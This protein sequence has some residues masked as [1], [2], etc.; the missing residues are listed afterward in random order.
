[1]FDNLLYQNVSDLL[2]SDIYNDRFPGSILLSGPDSSG[3]LT[4]ALEIARILSCKEKGEWACKCSS[5][6]KHKALTNTNLLLAGPRD[7]SLEIAASQKAFL[8]SAQSKDSHLVATR[9]LFIRSVRK[10]IL[11]F[12]PILY[13]GDD[14]LSKISSYTSTINEY[15][16]ELD[17]PRDLPNYEELESL[18]GNICKQCEKLETEFMYDSIP[19]NQIRNMSAWVHVPLPDA[20]K[21]V[22]I[23]K[24]DR[25]LEGVRNAM[26]KI[27]EEPPANTIFILTTSR[28]G[29][30]MPTILSRVR[31]Y[32]FLERGEQEQKE[33][34]SRVYH[35][36][37]N[38]DIDSYLQT[39][40]PIP[41]QKVQESA[42]IF[43]KTI[44]NSGI[45]NVQQIVKDCDK[46][47]PR[48]LMRIFLESIINQLDNY[49]FTPAG[50]KASVECLESIKNC[51]NNITIY[52]QSP[53]A[54]LEEL[55]KN[56]ASI[57]KTH[58][59]A[60]RML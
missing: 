3:K 23:E 43:F 30:V 25:M 55:V 28:R 53:Q 58:A 60:L 11:R 33:I 34:I 14:K 7:C 9:Y 17:P 10:L 47:D 1:M 21:V 39:F 54:A 4:A 56:I 5:C 31:T 45:P 19:V 50:T 13:Q 59:Y 37:T 36:Q 24:A 40:L 51:W 46:F 42:D 2:S 15:L 6:L 32:T 29:A 44:V 35:E 8:H 16:E 18:C 12:N 26:L 48:V 52:N 27:L 38:L 22:I 41:P 49:I 57:N 20:K